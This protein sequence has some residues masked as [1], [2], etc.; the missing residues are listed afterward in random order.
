MTEK[1][2]DIRK[3]SK[4]IWYSLHEYDIVNTWMQA[5]R[6]FELAA[7]PKKA[8]INVTADTNYRLY[9]NG[10]HVLRGPA[11]GFQ[12]AVPGVLAV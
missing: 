10:V 7:V 5:R 9:V 1:E 12:D 4:W 11:R 6:T 2:M 8:E 3:R